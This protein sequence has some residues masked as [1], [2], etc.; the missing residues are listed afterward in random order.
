VKSKLTAFI[1]L[2]VSS[3]LLFSSCTR[4]DTTDLGN[5]LIPAIDNVNTF[6]TTL[7]VITDNVLVDDTTRMLF[8]EYHAIGIIENDPDFGKTSAYT[9]VSFTPPNTPFYPFVKKDT[10]SIDSVV[11]SLAYNRL[12]GD[13]NS[14]Q[15][16]EVR[17]IFNLYDF[18]DTAHYI[19]GS[20]IP[21][22]S[23]LVGSS[24]FNFVNL[25]DMVFY[26]NKRDTISG[27]ELRIKLDTAWGRRFVN[28]DTT[29]T[30]NGA[31]H[32][33]SIFKRRFKGFEIRTNEASPNKKALA[34]FNLTDNAHTRLTFYCRVQN[35]GKT[36]TIAPYFV[37]KG[38]DPEANLIRR[39]PANAYLANLDDGID[40]DE[41]LYLQTTPG[42][43]IKVKIPALES[44]GNR[45]IHRA[46]LIMEQA[47]STDE[48]IFTAP[49]TMFIEAISP[50][51]D[52][53][54]T[55]RNDFLPT[56]A[57]PGYD[58][59]LLG[60]VYKNNKYVFNLSRYVQSIVTKGFPNYALKVH[61]PFT[62][63][64]NYMIANSNTPSTKVRMVINPSLAGGRVVLY[65]G[66]N[67]D[68]TKRMR[69]H[70]IYSKI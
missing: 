28:Y 37:F 12:Y 23:Q 7:T 35:N 20:D 17:E 27:N 10:V 57:N 11:L 29:S 9:Y 14:V 4:I 38:T 40:N 70:I 56:Q 39:T 6:D 66:S 51:G 58:L 67:A 55:I 18:R 1:I 36:D 34:Y 31:Y 19:G 8:T 32:N 49:P 22:E 53:T 46:E 47:P 3:I 15:Q 61:S 48:S 21:V 24:N 69:L 65:G 68:A 44:L 43:Y 2:V 30:A 5:Q 41:L 62:T 42:S 63:Q 60:G 52:S 64:P 13:S 45:V 33:D 25:N 59:N 26:R 16:F 54:Y 50:N